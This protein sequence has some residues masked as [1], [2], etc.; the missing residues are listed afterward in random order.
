MSTSPSLVRVVVSVTDLERALEFYRDLLGLPA[1]VVPGFATLPLGDGTDVFL[2]ERPSAPSDSGVAPSFGV[3]DLDDLC[4]RWAAAGGTIV[5]PPASQPWG[6]RMAV[7]RDAD[8][9]LV[10]L[11]ETGPAQELEQ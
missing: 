6:E 2:H 3:G 9:H 7:V 11:V 1:T 8:G 5:D 4:S 10:C